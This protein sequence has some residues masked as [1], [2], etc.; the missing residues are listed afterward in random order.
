[1]VIPLTDDA[2]AILE[3]RKFTTAKTGYV[4]PSDLGSTPYYTNIDRPWRKIREE[5]GINNVTIHGLRHTTCSWMGMTGA[6]GFEIKDAAGHASIVTTMD[7]THLQKDGI[8]NAMQKAVDALRED[9]LT[10]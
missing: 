3:R 4:F 6:N 8:R 7:Y 10:A 1:M 9:E 2:I 5:A